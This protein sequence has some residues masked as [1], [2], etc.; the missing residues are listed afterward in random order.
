MG[1]PGSGKTTQSEL[2]GKRLGILHIYPGRLLRQEADT[3]S[4]LASKIQPHLDA[5]TMVSADIVLQ[6]V[7]REMARSPEGYALDGFPRDMEQAI[8]LEAVLHKRS[9]ELDAVVNLELDEDEI[10]RRL[11]ARGRPDD[12][13]EIISR[14]IELFHCETDPVLQ[15]YDRRGV[16]VSVSGRGT[17]AQVT[18]RVLSAIVSQVQLS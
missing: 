4:P 16:L 6:L 9:E 5:G 15:F 8:K 3:G 11:L 17:T 1:P 2:I 10:H 18:E 13:P 7:E 14:R 12:K